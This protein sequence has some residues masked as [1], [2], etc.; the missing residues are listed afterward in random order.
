MAIDAMTPWR[1]LAVMGLVFLNGFFVAAEFA[2]VKV[3]KT[4]LVARAQRGEARAKRAL[5]VV[6]HLDAYLSAT[7][8]G[9]TLA[10]LGLGWVGEPFVAVLIGPPLMAAG[11]TDV[12]VIEVASFTIAFV[13]ITLLHI[14]LGELAPKSL[15]I[16]RAERVAIWTA[17]PL[18]VFYLTFKPFIWALNG[19][20]NGLLKLL[21]LRSVSEGDV[22]SEEEL[23]ILMRTAG[24]RKTITPGRAQL[25]ARTLELKDLD[26]RNVMTSRARMVALDAS[27]TFEENLALAEGSG[28][29]RFPVIE[30]DADKVLGMVHYRDVA[31][32]A[33]SDKKDLRLALRSILF[34][35]ETRDVEDVLGD[36]LK[37]NVHMA[38]VTDEFGSTA[39]I[40]TLEDIFEEIFGEIRD[41]FDTTEGESG[42][43]EVADGHYV[44]VGDL[45]LHQARAKLALA[46]S[47]HDVTTIGGYIAAELG[48]L[49]QRGEQFPLG[50]YDVLVRDA[51]RRRIHAFEFRRKM[52]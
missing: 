35:P 25:I 20:A 49:P 16:Q 33:R 2:I 44:L 27:R 22:E 31:R 14:V 34:V 24:L 21:G 19:L 50:H 7:Q 8:L 40:L 15:A 48:H 1:L 5:L 51:D 23:R 9:I 4:Q 43:T 37:R 29:S 26:A 47:E 42:I 28:Y 18:R 52:G 41:E 6:E 36:L 3:R 32:L 11:I 38:I 46:L 13:I 30:G 12:H 10:S 17:G 39:G 45:P